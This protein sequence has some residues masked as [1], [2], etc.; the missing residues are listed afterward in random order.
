MINYQL[1]KTEMLV[2]NN[3]QKTYSVYQLFQHNWKNVL[4][5]VMVYYK[6]HQRD[7]Y[8]VVIKNVKNNVVVKFIKL[9]MMDIIS[10]VLHN[11]KDILLE[12]LIHN[13]TVLNLVQKENYMLNLFLLQLQDNYVRNLA[14]TSIK[15][16]NVYHNVI[17]IST[18]YKMKRMFVKH[19]VINILFQYHSMY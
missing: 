5:N 16:I 11:V 2:L 18:Q 9:R 7:K 19:L 6:I 13:I 12:V 10:N 14:N 3:V 17:V 1:M 8:L 15:V 4:V